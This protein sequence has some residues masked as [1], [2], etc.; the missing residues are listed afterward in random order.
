MNTRPEWFEEIKID[1]S[2]DDR[3]WLVIAGAEM[4]DLSFG[5]PI[6]EWNHYGKCNKMWLDVEG[7]K[8]FVDSPETRNALYKKYHHELYAEAI[9]IVIER[10]HDAGHASCAELD[11]IL[12]ECARTQAA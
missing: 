2:N 6:L 5:T 4:Y 8:V 7:A 12:K 1:V 9:R 11:F 10:V 3:V